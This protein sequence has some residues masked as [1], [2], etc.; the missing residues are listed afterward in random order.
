MRFAEG[1]SIGQKRNDESVRPLMLA[2]EQDRR[3]V[4]C[5]NVIGNRQTKPS[6]LCFGNEQ[7]LFQNRMRKKSNIV[8]G[9]KH[10]AYFY[11]KVN[12]LYIAE[13]F[14]VNESTSYSATVQCRLKGNPVISTLGCPVINPRYGR[15]GAI[16][17]WIVEKEVRTDGIHPCNLADWVRINPLLE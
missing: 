14:S 5:E 4:R 13:Y 3:V 2:V 11:A 1:F 10:P 17:S 8:N 6:S 12:I 9:T 16:M 7:L 15:C